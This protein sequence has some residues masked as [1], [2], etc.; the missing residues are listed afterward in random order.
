MMAIIANQENGESADWFDEEDLGLTGI[1][2]PNEEPSANT[3]AFP[4][5]SMKDHFHSPWEEE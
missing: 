2:I 4:V 1:A 3:P 5:L